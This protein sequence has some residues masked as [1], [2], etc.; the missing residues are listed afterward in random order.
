MVQVLFKSALVFS[1][2]PT[3]KDH[4]GFSLVKAGFFS[5]R[6]VRS[7][8]LKFSLAHFGVYFKGVH[9][10]M[11]RELSALGTFSQKAGGELTDARNDLFSIKK[12]S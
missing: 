6:A 11:L 7:G 4:K 10:D 12:W 9:A 3:M 2:R 8:D 5:T 1:L